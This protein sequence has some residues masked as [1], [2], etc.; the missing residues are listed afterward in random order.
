M[1]RFKQDMG[2]GLIEGIPKARTTCSGEWVEHYELVY[3]E[4]VLQDGQGL[5]DYDIPP[6][7]IIYVVSVTH[8]IGNNIA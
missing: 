6:N 5:T 7:A 4:Q 3:S 1:E 8:A 2:E